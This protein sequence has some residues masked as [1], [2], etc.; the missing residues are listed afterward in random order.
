MIWLLSLIDK[1]TCYAAIVKGKRMNND[2]VNQPW[3]VLLF[4]VLV[5]FSHVSFAAQALE[6]KVVRITDGDTIT[7]EA[8]G[9]R[10]KVRL[11]GIDTP[12][13]D[14]PWGDAATREMR[15]MVAGKHVRVEWYKKDRWKRLIGNVYVDGE[16][17]GLLM[18]ERGMAWHFKRYAKEQDPEDRTAYAEVEKAAQ[19]AR[20]GLW[21]DPNP[22]PPREW[23]RKN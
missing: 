7:V 2:P 5:L 18:I 8:N 20:R 9:N 3:H 4:A 13:R 6:G 10:H 14:Q 22:V 16:D 23:R 17:V 21:S 11:S 15:R 12:E 1:S 19:G